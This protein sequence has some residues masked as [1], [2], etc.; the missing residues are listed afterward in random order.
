MC[1]RTDHRSGSPVCVRLSLHSLRPKTDRLNLQKLQLA[2]RL[3]AWARLSAREFI[4]EC[5][6]S[7]RQLFTRLEC[8]YLVVSLLAFCT[9]RSINKYT[10]DLVR[11]NGRKQTSIQ[12]NTTTTTTLTKYLRVALAFTKR[13]DKVSRFGSAKVHRTYVCR[14]YVF[15]LK[16]KHVHYFI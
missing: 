14:E 9:I 8:C 4:Y 5:A 15:V 13:R 1:V 7:G 11:P 2:I 3:A 6:G 10:A 12:H 16:V